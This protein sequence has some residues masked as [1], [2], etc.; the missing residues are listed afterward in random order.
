M[1]KFLDLYRQDK[2]LHKS[3]INSIRKLFKK[4]DFIQGTEVKEFEKNFAKF[5]G[6][7]F[8]ISCGNGTDALTIALKSLN[9]P[10][11]SEVLLPAMTYCSTAFAVINA[12][13]KPVLVDVS[14]LNSTIDLN[15]LKKKITKKTKVVLPVHLYGSVANLKQIKSIIK[16]K[17]IFLIDDCAQAHGAYDDS[18][19]IIKTKIG[20]S[21]DISCFSFYPGK[22]IGA[23]GD[24]GII[25]TNKKKFYKII[26]KFRNLG[27]E[28]KSVHEIVGVN[29][30]LDTIQALILNKKLKILNKLN[31]KRRNIAKIYNKKII[32]K[33]IKKIQY[34]KTCVYHQYVILVKQK[35][36]LIKLLD[37]KKI[38]YGF[39]Y[40]QAIH[41]LGAFK[42]YFK[43][44]KFNNAERLAKDGISIPIDPNLSK[45][46]INFIIET[47]NSL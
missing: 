32:S 15:D 33:K 41:Q 39:H 12:N 3:I 36:K 29:S 7:K 9:L 43:N 2:N 24:G 17:K 26:K 13:L 22:N 30:R 6:S 23:Y 11:Q 21:T 47:L 34:S 20:S 44:Q 8:A 28:K 16:N 37:K 38:E 25:T 31:K 18:E 27:S 4:A 1:I 45:K 42:N 14:F 46:N 19:K 35:K 40:N 10:N 5:C